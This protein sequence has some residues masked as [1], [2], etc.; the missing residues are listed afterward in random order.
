MHYRMARMAMYYRAARGSSSAPI[1]NGLNGR[2]SKE[3]KGDEMESCNVREIEKIVRFRITSYTKNKNT[4]L[5]KNKTETK[6][7]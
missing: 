2:W 7:K 6:L 1:H 4:A 5:R 3:M